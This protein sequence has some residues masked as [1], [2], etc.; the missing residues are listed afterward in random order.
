MKGIVGHSRNRRVDPLEREPDPRRDPERSLVEQHQ[1]A[2]VGTDEDEVGA[3][4]NEGARPGAGVARR[5]CKM[6]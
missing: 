4:P 3:V 6:V 2:A 1:A 5:Y